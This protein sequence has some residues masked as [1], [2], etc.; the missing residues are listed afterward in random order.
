MP[1]RR[2]RRTVVTRSKGFPDYV[3]AVGPERLRRT[4]VYDIEIKDLTKTKAEQERADRQME[5]F[6]RVLAAPFAAIWLLGKMVHSLFAMPE[7]GTSFD[8]EMW[9]S[10]CN[11]TETWVTLMQR[12]RDGSPVAYDLYVYTPGDFVWNLVGTWPEHG[13]AFAAKDWWVDYAE[14]GGT[15]QTWLASEVVNAD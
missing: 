12:V 1:T 8:L 3:P 7:A 11:T 10:R 14:Q 13:P 6:C 15:Y 9:L 4:R 2:Y 5:I